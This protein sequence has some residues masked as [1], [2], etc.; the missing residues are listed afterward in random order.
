MG[1]KDF[2]YKK[3]FGQKKVCQNKVL[4]HNYKTPKKLGPKSLVDIGSVT[5]EILMNKIGPQ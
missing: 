3:Y 5:A 1:T 2:W 4:D